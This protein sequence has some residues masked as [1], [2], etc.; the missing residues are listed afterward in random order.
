MY[1]DAL[2]FIGRNKT[3]SWNSNQNWRADHWRT[4]TL[5]GGCWQPAINPNIFPLIQNVYSDSTLISNYALHPQLKVKRLIFMIRKIPFSVGFW[6]KLWTKVLWSYQTYQHILFV[7]N[8]YT[9]GKTHEKITLLLYFNGISTCCAFAEPDD[10]AMVAGKKV[11][12][13]DTHAILIQKFGK[14]KLDTFYIIV[15]G[16]SKWCI[17]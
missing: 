10:F 6:C 2:G 15:V 1:G 14:P 17:N 4:I 5:N 12:I 3:I 16:N 9:Q 11:T 8:I 13:S 7:N